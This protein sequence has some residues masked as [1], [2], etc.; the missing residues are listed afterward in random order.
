MLMTHSCISPR[1]IKY[2][3]TDPKPLFCP[4]H[5]DPASSKVI[6]ILR[7]SPRLHLFCYNLDLVS[8]PFP[9]ASPLSSDFCPRVSDSPP[10]RLSLCWTTSPCASLILS[11]SLPFISVTQSFLQSDSLT[12]YFNPLSVCPPPPPHSS[13]PQCPN[14]SVCV[15]RLPFH[16]FFPYALLPSV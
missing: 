7:P 9:S 5:S 10:L 14:I 1:K 3:L 13:P 4:C 16:L 15:L 2:A 6:C 12:L 8:F 11:V